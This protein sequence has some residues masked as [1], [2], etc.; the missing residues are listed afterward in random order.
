[1]FEKTCQ[2]LRGWID[3]GFDPIRVSINC[4]RVHLKNP[5]FLE[6]YCT[7]ASRYRIPR[8]LI[9]IELTESI[10]MED[11]QRLLEVIDDIHDAGF[12]CSIDDFGSGYS[13]LNMIQSIPVDTLKLDKIFFH[14]RT[15]DRK[16]TKSVVQSIIS[17]A[18]ALNMQ[19][20][21]EGVE[22]EDQVEMLRNVG[23]D[24][25]QGYVFARPMPIADFELLAFDTTTPEDGD[26]L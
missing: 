9:E 21:A 11:A 7:I 16:R 19:T 26:V 25:A 6:P 2:T 4:S 18:Q 22:Y 15:K 1:M 23:C 14:D 12:T 13:S 20:V 17:M 3:R 5:R 10:V 24:Y 8:E